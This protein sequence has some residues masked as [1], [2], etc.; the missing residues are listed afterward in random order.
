MHSFLIQIF[1]FHSRFY[2]HNGTIC[3]SYNHS[4]FEPAKNTIRITEKIQKEQAENLQRERE[5]AEKLKKE[6]IKEKV[7]L[8]DARREYKKNLSIEARYDNLVNVLQTK[9][10]DIDI[11]LDELVNLL[12][13][14]RNS[15]IIIDSDKNPLFDLNKFDKKS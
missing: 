2:H 12:K 15:I 14:N 3:R 7:K 8:S 10:D 6:I 11:E 4:I 1:I 9:L 13:V 5:R